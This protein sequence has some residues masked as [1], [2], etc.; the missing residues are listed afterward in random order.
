MYT[1]TLDGTHT[2]IYKYHA[3]EV[4]YTAFLTARK[5]R[6]SIIENRRFHFFRKNNNGKSYIIYS[7]GMTR[8]IQN[9]FHQKRNIQHQKKSELDREQFSVKVFKTYFSKPLV[10]LRNFA[11]LYLQSIVNPTNEIWCKRLLMRIQSINFIMKNMVQNSTLQYTIKLF[12]NHSSRRT[13][14]KK[15]KQNQVPKSKVISI[16]IHIRE[17]GFNFCENGDEIHQQ[18]LPNIIDNRKNPSS[19]I[20]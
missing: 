1:C 11:P 6:A 13:L 4:V 20:R 3:L 10:D 9:S 5:T 8:T 14:V 2:Q 12:L 15:L 19:S 7:E 18:H 16:T 17:A